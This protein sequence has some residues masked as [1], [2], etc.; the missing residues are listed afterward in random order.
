MS[1]LKNVLHSFI[2][3]NFSFFLIA[4]YCTVF[5][6]KESLLSLEKS[7]KKSDKKVRSP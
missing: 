2:Y 6:F 7:L 5:K 1:F 4:Q 3:N